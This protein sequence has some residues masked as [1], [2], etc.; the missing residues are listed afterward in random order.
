MN[1]RFKFLSVAVLGFLMAG[2]SSVP[3]PHDP[4]VI[5]EAKYY[6]PENPIMATSQPT[7]I[8]ILNNR[9]ST[10]NSYYELLLG[11]NVAKIC[12]EST[13]CGEAS[14]LATLSYRIEKKGRDLVIMALL[15]RSINN[16]LGNTVRVGYYFNRPFISE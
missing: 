13:K 10:R 14:N 9:V 8:T 15:H 6:P 12:K 4:N 7:N 11:Q 16:Q 5:V 2:C 1:K 3:K